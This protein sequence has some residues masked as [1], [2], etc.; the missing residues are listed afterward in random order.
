MEE[1]LPEQSSRA[2]ITCPICYES[3]EAVDESQVLGCTHSFCKSCLQQHCELSIIQARKKRRLIL[4]CPD[5]HCKYELSNTEILSLLTPTLQANYHRAVQLSIGWLECSQCHVLQAPSTVTEKLT[6]PCGHSFCSIHGDA[7]SGQTCQEYIIM[8]SPQSNNRSTCTNDMLSNSIIEEMTKPCPHCTIR[9]AKD[10]GCHHVVCPSCDGDWCWTCQNPNLTG[11]CV[12]YCSCCNNMYLDHRKV[13][14]HRLLLCW[15]LPFV[16]PTA[17][18]YMLIAFVVCTLLYCCY[19]CWKEHD[20]HNVRRKL[21][22]L[23]IVPVLIIFS[24]FGFPWG[25]G[26]LKE[27]N[28]TLEGWTNQEQPQ[29]K[30][31]SPNSNYSQLT[32]P[33]E[34]EEMGQAVPST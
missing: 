10:G 7:H 34:D 3:L 29:P 21:W 19:Y 27:F 20:Q 4:A 11:D 9:I 5:A 23:M 33:S 6:C 18:L 30:N 28:D 17:L 13:W 32:V 24:D 25:E 16:L 22:I 15:T 31:E 8:A 2:E 12:R 14:K 1:S 26:M